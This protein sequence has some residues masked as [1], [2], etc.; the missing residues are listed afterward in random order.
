MD[1]G[2][3]TPQRKDQKTQ[4][5]KKRKSG[6]CREETHGGSAGRSADRNFSRHRTVRSGGPDRPVNARR[7]PTT[8]KWPVRLH[9][10]DRPVYTPD[11]PVCAMAHRPDDQP[12]VHNAPDRPMRGTGPS[13]LTP[14]DLDRGA[15]TRRRRWATALQRTGPSGVYTPDRPVSSRSPTVVS[16]G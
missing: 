7:R 8:G 15:A 9:A 3:K 2:H 4:D 1:L 10:P 16:N 6:R 13:G 12:P 5:I 14:D 11:R